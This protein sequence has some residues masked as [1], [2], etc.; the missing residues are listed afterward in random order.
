MQPDASAQP[1]QPSA[2]LLVIESLLTVVGGY[3]NAFTYLAHGH[4]FATAET[5]NVVLFGIDASSAHWSQA[6]LKV[7]PLLAFIAG[8]VVAKL[9]GV[10]TRKR[11]FRAT[12][13]CQALELTVLLLL[14]VFESRLRD[15]I[16]VSTISFVSALQITSFSAL[17]P[18]SF[19]S[20]M[21]TGNLR[22]AVS[23]L[24]AWLRGQDVAK[25][26]GLFLVSGCAC[27]SFLTGAVAGAIYTRYETRLALMPCTVLMGIA[28]LLTWR[29][30]QMHRRGSFDRQ[31][32]QGMPR[33]CGQDREP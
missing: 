21:T 8:I 26:R 30:R 5:G 7:Y 27:L 12:L 3:L 32:M 24:L 31:P 20:T 4:V 11:T 33:R 23:G 1:E 14:A 19:N 10:E 2:G 15:E 28:L 16:V 18:W 6:L 9:M 29:Q 17:G 25:S 13:I 22:R